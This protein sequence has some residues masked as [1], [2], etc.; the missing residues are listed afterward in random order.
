MKTTSCV[1]RRQVILVFF[2]DKLNVMKIYDCIFKG[3]IPIYSNI[4]NTR[5]K[6][7]SYKPSI[8]LMFF[9]PKAIKYRYIWKHYV[10]KM[11]MWIE[12][13]MAIMTYFE[14]NK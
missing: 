14:V 11:Q 10:I 3:N 4:V 5:K 13:K 2:S 6:K 7:Y 1:L 8:C 12:I 9:L